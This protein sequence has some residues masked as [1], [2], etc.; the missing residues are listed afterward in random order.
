MN[1]NFTPKPGRLMDQVRE[2]LRFHHYSLSTEKSCVQSILRYIRF[3]NRR[4][5]K[6]WVNLKSSDI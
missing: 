2:V 3:N 6:T 5:P 1:T 4:H